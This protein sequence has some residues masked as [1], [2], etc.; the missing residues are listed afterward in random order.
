MQVRDAAELENLG[1]VIRQDK[2]LKGNIDIM[3]GLMPM[4]KE[5]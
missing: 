2:K 5:K 3:K 4:R 1:L